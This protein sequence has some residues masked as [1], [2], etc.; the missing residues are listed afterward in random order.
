MRLQG[1]CLRPGSG[2][3]ARHRCCSSNSEVNARRTL[4]AYMAIAKDPSTEDRN[5]GF[6]PYGCDAADD[7][8]C[9]DAASQQDRRSYRFLTR[10]LAPAAREIAAVG[11]EVL[12]VVT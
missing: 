9:V 12:P 5:Y 7:Q 8:S 3:A 11:A 10:S 2:V 4:T 6:W 1:G